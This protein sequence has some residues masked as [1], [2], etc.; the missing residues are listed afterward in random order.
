LP[1]LGA[2]FVRAFVQAVD[3]ATER[4]T[5]FPEVEGD[6]RRVILSRFPFG[7]FFRIIDDVIRIVR[8]IDLP[9][10]DRRWRRSLGS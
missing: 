5:S 10:D 7:V 8:V 1:G 2:R 3:L 6:V 4:P 9:S